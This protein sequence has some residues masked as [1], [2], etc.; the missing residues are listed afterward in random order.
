MEVN[1]K[2]YFRFFMK[3]KIFARKKFIASKVISLF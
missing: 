1:N 3:C 2:V